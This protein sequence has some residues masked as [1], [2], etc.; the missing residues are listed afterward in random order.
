M[1]LSRHSALSADDQV[2][3]SILRSFLRTANGALMINF[4]W[5][6]VVVDF[7]R[8]TRIVRVDP[9]ALTKREHVIL[10]VSNQVLN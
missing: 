6:Q 10:A 4:F 9:S 8:M 2:L 5:K 1:Y 3:V 7:F